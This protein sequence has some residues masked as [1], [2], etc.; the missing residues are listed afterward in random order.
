MPRQ[1]FI[2]GEGFLDATTVRQYMLPGFGF[3][4]E[5]ALSFS[6][7]FTET[8][9]S[10]DSLA[11]QGRFNI[12]N[13]ETAT[14][15]DSVVPFNN[16]ADF[17]T[18]T[19]AATDSMIGVRA[20]YASFTETA[21]AADAFNPLIFNRTFL[22]AGGGVL[23]ERGTRQYL[24]PGM[25]YVND[26][27]PYKV[28][29]GAY[30][31]FNAP[32]SDSATASDAAVAGLI[33]SITVSEN[34]TAVDSP[35]NGALNSAGYGNAIYGGAEYGFAGQDSNAVPLIVVAFN[36][37]PFTESVVPGDS[38]T[39]TRATYATTSDTANANDGVAV[40]AQSNIDV[41]ETAHA[42]DN[43]VLKGSHFVRIF[44]ILDEN[45]VFV[46]PPEPGVEK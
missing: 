11:V 2:P 15:G 46:V 1:F 40:N 7:S 30:A 12:A 45:R 35:L 33:A 16:F 23:N 39:A 9:T 32:T 37:P 25:G 22:I 38:V 41:S 20:V 14:A 19:V 21:A 34:A 44:K 10:A 42:T 29:A 17:I 27:S 26:V 24:V 28:L 31:A 3:I 13:T 5:R 6:D 8:V 36:P 43:Q 4:N 18:E